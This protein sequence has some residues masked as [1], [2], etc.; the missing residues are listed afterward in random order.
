MQTLITSA[1]VIERAFRDGEY[2]APETIDDTSI[3]T[4]QESYIRPMTGDA[5]YEKL[6]EGLHAEF[7]EEYL[8]PPLALYVRYLMAPQLD[9]RH[10][11][12]GTLQ[13]RSDTFTAASDDTMQRSRRTLLKNARRLLRRASDYLDRHTAEFPDYDPMSNILNRCSIDG[14][15]VQIF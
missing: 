3:V 8:A 14:E 2:I 4:A 12:A 11:Q 1:V 13:P 5:L 10:G 9:I 15:F 6:L 7:V